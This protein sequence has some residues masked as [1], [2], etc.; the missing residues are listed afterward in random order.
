[1]AL[2]VEYGTLDRILEGLESGVER[3]RVAAEVGAS[4]DQVGQ[5]AEMTRRSLHMRRM[6]PWPEL[7][8]S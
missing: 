6:P 8:E 3:D 4:L 1:M 2:G 5:V 7:G